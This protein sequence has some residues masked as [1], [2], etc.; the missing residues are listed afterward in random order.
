M[1]ILSEINP[2]LTDLT[3]LGAAGVM[4]VMWLW[5]RHTSRKREEQLNEAHGRIIN[6]RVQLDQLIDV[7]R[8]NSD[9]MS[10]LCAM[11][12][13]LVRELSGKP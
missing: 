11:Q 6:D 1:F 12:E 13:Q 10:R 8:S 7:V 5:E 3:N 9:A 4:G 2:A